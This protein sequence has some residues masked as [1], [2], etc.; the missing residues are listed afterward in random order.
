MTAGAVRRPTARAPRPRRARTCAAYAGVESYGSS[1]TSTIRA[2]GAPAWIAGAARTRS[3][4]PL[5]GSMR[6]TKPTIGPPP[7]SA[8][9]HGGG[10]S[11]A[12]SST[13]Q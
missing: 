10:T 13:G 12:S 6:P 9:G 1:P 8:D 4:G 11:A 3:S 2:P 7:L 5:R